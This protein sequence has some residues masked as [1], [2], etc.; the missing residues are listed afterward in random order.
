MEKVK[1][2]KNA[3]EYEVDISDLMPASL[4]EEKTWYNQ[5]AGIMDKL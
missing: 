2:K 1:V 3:R 5:T 4:A